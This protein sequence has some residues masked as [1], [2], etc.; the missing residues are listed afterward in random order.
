L[1]SI[2]GV[3][4]ISTGGFAFGLFSSFS[5]G[6]HVSVKEAAIFDDG[7]GKLVLLNKGS[8]DDSLV[9]VAVTANDPGRYPVR[10]PANSETVVSLTDVTDGVDSLSAGQQVTMKIRLANE[11][12][13]SHVVVVDDNLE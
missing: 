8:A 2:L 13:L 4:G 10:L 6:P 11:V 3:I 12:V 1:F 5:N 7:S 9:G